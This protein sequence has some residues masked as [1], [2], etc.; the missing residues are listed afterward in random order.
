MFTKPLS[1]IV[2]PTA[3]KEAY[4]EINKASSGIDEVSFVEFEKDLNKNIKQLS[5]ELMQSTYI[6]EPH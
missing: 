6:P 5:K 1:Y 3:L 2:L 4:F